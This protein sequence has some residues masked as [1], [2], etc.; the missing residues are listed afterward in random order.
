[1]LT[2]SAH[3]VPQLQKLGNKLPYE[4][5]RPAGFVRPEFAGQAVPTVWHMS[6]E[7]GTMWMY[8]QTNSKMQP[9]AG[10]VATQTR[11]VPDRKPPT[12]SLHP[13]LLHRTSELCV[14]TQSCQLPFGHAWQH[15]CW[16]CTS[17]PPIIISHS[18]R[19]AVFMTFPHSQ[20]FQRPSRSEYGQL[21][22]RGHGGVGPNSHDDND[23]DEGRSLDSHKQAIPNF[24]TPA[25]TA[26]EVILGSRAH[27]LASETLQAWF[28]SQGM[29]SLFARRDD[30]DRGA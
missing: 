25:R 17:V 28:A 15:T 2:S 16:H 24:T 14:L 3:T 23:P 29:S 21:G 22:S 12:S 9:S 8:C 7:C 30:D 26:E 10:G 6:H 27:A 5:T 13:R 11:T 19:A 20:Q 4:P 18:H 1:M